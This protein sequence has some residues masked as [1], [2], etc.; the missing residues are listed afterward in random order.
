MFA[1]DPSLIGIISA[2]TALTA[3]FTGPMVSLYVA[4]VQIRASVRSA[5]RQRW[6]EDF[7]E[8]IASLCG[9][10][11]VVTQV[12]ERMVE[13]GRLSISSE[14]DLKQLHQLISAATK[15]RLMINPI[16]PD[17]QALL[18]RVERL[19]TLFRTAATGDDVQEHARDTAFEITNLS[20]AII[21]H[22]W[23]RVQKGM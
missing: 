4:R 14:A 11:A 19:L 3:S 12:R 18:A 13:S 21:R 6:I 5:N 1:V 7:R 22:E 2:C 23:T 10:I 17:H 9:Q 16:E 20:L 8:T 15:I